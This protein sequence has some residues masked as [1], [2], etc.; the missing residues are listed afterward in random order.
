M[1]KKP[2]NNPKYILEADPEKVRRE[3]EKYIKEQLVLKLNLEIASTKIEELRNSHAHNNDLQG[4]VNEH[5]LNDE[6]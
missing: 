6:I 3:R 4:L 2:V 1:N 5:F